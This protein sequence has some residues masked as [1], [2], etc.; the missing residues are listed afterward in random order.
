M[1]SHHLVPSL[2][3]LFRPRKRPSCHKPWLCDSRPFVAFMEMVA[4][5]RALRVSRVCD[6]G[7]LP[8]PNRLTNGVAPP[9]GVGRTRLMPSAAPGLLR[10]HRGGPWGSVLAF[11]EI[12]TSVCAG[13]GGGCCLPFWSYPGNPP[14]FQRSC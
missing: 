13:G 4:K 2:F 7:A 10:Q 12:I 8:W 11:L 1:T 6:T 3:V 9:R 5:S 14:I